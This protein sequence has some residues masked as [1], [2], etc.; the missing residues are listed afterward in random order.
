M[1]ELPKLKHGMDR[2]FAIVGLTK[3]LAT[4]YLQQNLPLWCKLLGA[5]VELFT[6]NTTDIVV[7][8][9]NYALEEYQPSFHKLHS[10]TS[11]KQNA[12]PELVFGQSM[13]SLLQSNP[14]VLEV[15][16]T[17]LQPQLY[18]VFA[19]KVGIA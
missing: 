12:N 9:E 3:V 11:A 19:T 17:N 15:I 14:S 7:A 18:Q 13:Q 4:Q 1:P 2:N 6:V 16:K 5:V 8:D 10:T